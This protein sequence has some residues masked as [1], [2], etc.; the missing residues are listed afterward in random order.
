MYLGCQYLAY[1]LLH[2]VALVLIHHLS[3]HH[4]ALCC[5]IN[6]FCVLLLQSQ[7]FQ[8]RCLCC[9]LWYWLI[10]LMR[11]WK[12][13]HKLNEFHILWRP[14]DHLILKPSQVLSIAYH[15]LFWNIHYHQMRILCLCLLSYCCSVQI[16]F[17]LNFHMKQMPLWLYVK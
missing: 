7:L 17:S 6:F 14:A 15:W 3:L 2:V 16:V 8:L 11:V 12:G 13:E 4:L 1:C 10:M 5:R 9:C